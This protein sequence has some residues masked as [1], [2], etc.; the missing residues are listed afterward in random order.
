MASYS[1][2]YDGRFDTLLFITTSPFRILK[3]FK[4]WE[5]EILD[6]IMAEGF[7]QRPLYFHILCNP[8]CAA[9]SRA[10]R[11]AEKLPHRYGWFSK[12]LTGILLDSSPSGVLTTLGSRHVHSAREFLVA[13]WRF[14]RLRKWMVIGAPFVVVGLALH[15]L[16]SSVASTMSSEFDSP[17]RASDDFLRF[18]LVLPHVTWAL[19]YDL[20]DRISTGRGIEKFVRDM[21]AATASRAPFELC[22]GES[23]HLRHITLHHDA[24]IA[25][26]HRCFPK[27]STQPVTA[28]AVAA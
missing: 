2:R 7:C 28:S 16:W 15:T 11:L 24:Y 12:G 27:L 10:L 4:H 9:L 20:E 19:V 26:V 23:E 8:G 22:L 5:V 21:R 17:I 18:S 6:V 25:F 1:G 13:M 3:N 14:R